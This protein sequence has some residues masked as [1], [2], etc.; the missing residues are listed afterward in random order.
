VTNGTAGGTTLLRRP[1][2]LSDEYSSPV[3]AAADNLVF[4]SA[5]ETTDGIEPWVS[6]GTVAGT[7]RL[8]DIAAPAQGG[9]SYPREFFRQGSRVYFSA[10]DDTL[11]SQLWSSALSN[12]CAAPEEAL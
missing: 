9:S 4:F 8:K 5:Y 7:R 3:Y 12:T 2:S 10:Y 6:N 1:L 11:N